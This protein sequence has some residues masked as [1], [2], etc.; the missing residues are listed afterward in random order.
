MEPWYEVAAGLAGIG[1]L[2]GVVVVTWEF[3]RI[4]QAIDTVWGTLDDVLKDE[5]MPSPKN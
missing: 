2:C 3:S 1:A 5:D 4:Y